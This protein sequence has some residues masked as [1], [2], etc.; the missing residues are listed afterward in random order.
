LFVIG[1]ASFLIWFVSE[2]KAIHAKIA[3]GE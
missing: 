3:K 1:L 2:I